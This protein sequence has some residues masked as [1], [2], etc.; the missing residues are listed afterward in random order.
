[1][2]KNKGLA[3]DNSFTLKFENTTNSVRTIT[4]FEQ[5][6]NDPTDVIEVNSA[7][8]NASQGNITQSALIW[9]FVAQQPYQYDASVSPITAPINVDLFKA[10]TSGNLEIISDNGGSK[11]DVAILNTDTLNQV[12]DKINLAIRN[13]ADLTNFKSPSGLFAEVNVLFDINYFEQFALPQAKTNPQYRE[14][15]GVSVQYPTDLPHKLLEINFPTN[16]NPEFATL[17]TM[18]LSTT[19]SANGVIVQDAGVNVTYEE[20]E[21][22]QSGAVYDIRSMGLDVGKAPTQN[23]KDGQMLSPFCF[24]KFDVNGNE[25]TYCKVPTKDPYQFQDS[26]GVIDMGTESDN[27]V[28]DGRTKFN[29]DVQPLT[30]LFL[31]FNYAQLTNL[32]FDTELGLAQAKK[33][34]DFL[35][36]YDKNRNINRVIKL[37]APEYKQTKNKPK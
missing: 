24:T 18:L 35:T 2:K 13:N 15:F 20:I 33:E 6:G 16:A 17:N 11:V 31:T 3:I 27:Y 23:E 30:S 26:Y 1:L 32:L 9:N 21:R 19:S 22:S 7:F 28:L 5:G 29:Y 25:L 14:S 8:E 37:T 34:Q 10:T 36:K 4:L 12:N